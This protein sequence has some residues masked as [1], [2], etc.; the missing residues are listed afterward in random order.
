MLMAYVLM[1]R[2]DYKSDRS[3][4]MRHVPYLPFNL[5]VNK[6]NKIVAL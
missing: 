6:S 1:R 2:E 5:D 3:H 4:A